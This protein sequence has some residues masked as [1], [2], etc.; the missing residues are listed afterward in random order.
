MG[1][2]MKQALLVIDFIE[3]IAKTG[4]CAQFLNENPQV[5][6][7]IN[8]LT[9]HFREKKAPIFHIRLAFDSNYNDLP[10]NAPNRSNLENGRKFL[11][12]QPDTRFICEIEIQESDLML[13]KKHGDPFYKSGLKKL[14]V[15]KNVE[16]IVFTGLATDNAILFGAHSAM[17]QN[18]S[19]VV[20]TDATG[21]ASQEAHD[22]AL[23]IMKGR[24][25]NRL[26]TTEEFLESFSFQEQIP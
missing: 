18:F 2:E 25:V 9:Q 20:I 12:G 23:L 22:H 10:Q 24:V 13:N 3:G 1:K 19:C 7:N 17:T 26:Q 14:L 4:S 6:A 5:F 11:L 16:E 21:A 15:T 8:R